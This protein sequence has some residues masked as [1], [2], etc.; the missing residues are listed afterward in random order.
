MP[1]ITK[2]QRKA[3]DGGHRPM[4]PGELN[5]A[6]T[7]QCLNFLDQYGHNYTDYNAVIGALECAKLE[8]YRRLVGPYEDIKIRANGDIYGKDQR[9]TEDFRGAV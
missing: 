9:T 3:V 2:E 1:Y 5:Y 7:T 6:I 8:F 4:S